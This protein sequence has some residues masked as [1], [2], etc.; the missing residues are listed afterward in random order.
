MLILYNDEFCLLEVYY[1]D[2]CSTEL[3]MFVAVTFHFLDG[4][5]VLADELFEDAS[6]GAVENSHARL[7]ELDG[8]V[9]EVGDGL[10]GF[11]A[12][13][14][15]YINVGLEIELTCTHFVGSGIAN[16]C[17]FF[18]FRN[19][20]E[21]SFKFGQ[22]HSSFQVAKRH[23]GEF[24]FNA[25]DVAHSGRALHHHIVAHFK[26]QVSRFCFL[27]GFLLS[28]LLAIYITIPT[29]ARTGVNDDGFK[30]LTKRL[31]D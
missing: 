17:C 13:H 10:N 22:F 18:W 7:T 8:I 12:A 9:D 2:A 3:D 5:E 21:S 24:P 23:D 11:V 19:L 1:C 16:R 14:A 15:T 31:V 25:H 26:L 29:S 4:I 6:T 28:F 30:S 27:F 20:F